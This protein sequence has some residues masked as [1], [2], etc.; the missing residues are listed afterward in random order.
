MGKEIEDSSSLKL[1]TSF[2]LYSEKLK[3]SCHANRASLGV[4]SKSRFVCFGND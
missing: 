2:S 3:S 4:F 1:V